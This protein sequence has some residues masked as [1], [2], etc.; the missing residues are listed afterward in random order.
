[1]AYTIRA[2]QPE[3]IPKLGAIERSAGQLF[4]TVGLDAVADDEPMPSEVLSSYLGAGNL[5]VT[6][7][8]DEVVGFLAVFPL[9]KTGATRSSDERFLHIAELSVHASHQRKGIAKGLL[10]HLDGVARQSSRRIAGLSL[11]TYR[12]LAFNGPFYA[13]SG[14]EEIEKN[15]IES[16]VGMRGRELWEE[17]QAKIVARERRCWMVKWIRRRE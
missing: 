11:T 13:T 15:E 3:D 6:T 16:V 9:T 2:A 7:V 14:F 12:D 4:K 5:W 8:G 17:E 1:M 10:N